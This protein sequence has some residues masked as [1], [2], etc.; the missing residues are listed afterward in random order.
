[1]TTFTATLP[2]RA[3]GKP[4]QTRSDKW[5]KR[6]C[7]LAYRAFADQVRALIPAEVR[8]ADVVRLDWVATFTPPESWSNKR[9]LA[10]I[11][12]PHRSKP[13]RDNIDK[14]LMDSL[15][16]EDSGI[17]SGTISKVW[18]ERDQIEL[19]FWIL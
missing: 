19:T 16:E 3:I 2:L 18:G 5:R 14:A 9:K 13:D 17:A 7:V 6:P 8:A 10:S 15:F 11:G 4:R 1:M 12:Q